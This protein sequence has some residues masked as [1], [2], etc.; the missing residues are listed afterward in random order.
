MSTAERLLP[1]SGSLVVKRKACES[2]TDW[3]SGLEQAQNLKILFK[4]RQSDGK[5]Q[6][7]AKFTKDAGNKLARRKPLDA[8]CDSELVAMEVRGS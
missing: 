8:T 4:P 2:I 3:I 7:K 5:H 6:V 1:P